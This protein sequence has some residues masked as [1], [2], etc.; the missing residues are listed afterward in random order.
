MTKLTSY[1][2]GTGDRFGQQGE[3][4]LK[5][6]QKAQNELGAS[7]TPVWNKSNREHQIIGTQPQ[8]VRQ[9]ADKAVKSLQWKE[10]YFVDADHITLETVDPYLNCSDFFTL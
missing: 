4:Q 2:F 1:S 7:I 3:A 5:A 10:A 8:E 6:V 9:E